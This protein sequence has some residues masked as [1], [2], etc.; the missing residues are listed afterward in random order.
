MYSFGAADVHS[1]GIDFGNLAALD[2]PTAY[3]AA[4]Q[5]IQNV[6][7]GGGSYFFAKRTS[8]N[9]GWGFRLSATNQ[10]DVRHHD[11]ATNNNVSSTGTLTIGTL[12]S[13]VA[14]WDGSNMRFVID[15]SN[16]SN[17]AFTRAAATN[18]SVVVIGNA[19]GLTTG[20]GVSL[21][22][23]MWWDV[24]LTQEE[25]E[26]WH[27][28]VIAR[29][30]S[31]KFWA[32]GWTDPGIEIIGQATATKTGTVTNI[33]DA[34]AASTIP[35]LHKQSPLYGTHFQSIYKVISETLGLSEGIVSLVTQV[36]VV[37]ETLGLHDHAEDESGY[38]EPDGQIVETVTE[39]ARSTV[40]TKKFPP[41]TRKTAWTESS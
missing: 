3:T 16:D 20:N 38:L 35:G 28:G 37:D 11:G 27:G 30:A 15:G 9:K 10:I 32:P 18:A 12:A 22:H 17:P 4:F 2:A 26:S 14:S 25:C 7:A 8:V 19:S 41:F 1:N 23:V 31:L 39:G 6:A 13:V 34:F 29:P 24:A 21:G 40:W 36:K 5:I 33:E